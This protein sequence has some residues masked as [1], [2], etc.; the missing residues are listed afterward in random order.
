MSNP[1]LDQ[2]LENLRAQELS[3]GDDPQLIRQGMEQA[4]KEMPRAETVDCEQALVGG[5]AG[6]WL[7][8]P[9]AAAGKAILY[10]HGGGYVAGSAETHAGLVSHLAVDTG[11]NV[12]I[13]EYRLAPEH[14]FP[15]GLEDALA[16]Y[17]GL[18][19][20]G[21][22]SIA[23]AG[24]SAGG[25]LSVSLLIDLKL[26]SQPLPACAVLWSP[27][28]D[29]L[30]EGESVLRNATAD[31]ILAPD[32]LTICVQRYVGEA[33]PQDPRLSPLQ[34]DLSG[35][36]PL[37][38][39]VGSTEILLSDAVRLNEAACRAHVQT[40]LEV[41]PGMPHVFQGFYF[42]LPEA[43]MALRDSAAFI[44]RHCQ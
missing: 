13:P 34:T 1:I 31:A 22:S 4:F 3:F 8:P 6:I 37:L 7:R 12:F 28:V 40:R 24:D 39:Q 35:L 14:P 32:S 41:Y 27:W 21:L 30:G 20:S 23:V 9:G 10:L 26:R 42:L 19:K 44:Q 25:G 15:A 36:P 29:L 11:I 2:L 17:D 16:C 5:V 43:A 38:I 18:R 33:I